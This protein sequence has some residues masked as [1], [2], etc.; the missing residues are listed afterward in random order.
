MKLE[1]TK[2]G[3]ERGAWMPNKGK[4][5][6]FPTFSWKTS[7]SLVSFHFPFSYSLSPSLSLSSYLWSSKVVK[8]LLLENEPSFLPGGIHLAA[9]LQPAPFFAHD[10]NRTRGWTIPTTKN[11]NSTKGKE[12]KP[13]CC[14][15]SLSLFLSFTFQWLALRLLLLAEMQDLRTTQCHKSK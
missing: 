6:P 8:K 10:E 2:K 7:I 5:Y 14:S 4:Q 9:F 1:N 11:T 3:K 15:L 13:V 12:G